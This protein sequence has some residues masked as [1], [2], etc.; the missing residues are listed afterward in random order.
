MLRKLSLWSEVTTF[1]GIPEIRTSTIQKSVFR[2]LFWLLVVFL[3]VGMLVWQIEVLVTDYISGDGYSTSMYTQSVDSFTIPPI[4]LCNYNRADSTK[5]QQLKMSSSQLQYFF[6]GFLTDYI[7]TLSSDSFNDSRSAFES[8][9][10]QNSKNV[11]D[12]TSLL[13]M[14]AHSCEDTIT[15]CI[16]GQSGFQKSCCNDTFTVHNIYGS[17]IAVNKTSLTQ[18]TPGPA[19]FIFLRI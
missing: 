17:C 7:F 10:S 1:H 6:S 9:K 4:V 8:F 19:H 15:A 11:S 18:T 12:S 2:F 14:L 13:D 16:Y 5:V 3:A